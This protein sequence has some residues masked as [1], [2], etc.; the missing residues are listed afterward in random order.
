M[1]MRVAI[2]IKLD[3]L[4]YRRFAS[5][6]R[7]L[8]VHIN[9][10]LENLMRKF[11]EEHKDQAPLDLYLTQGDG[12]T[13]II[14]FNFTQ[15]NYNII[16]AKIAKLD[17]EGWLKKIEELEPEL[18]EI[19]DNDLQRDFW[20]KQLSDLILEASKTIEELKAAGEYDYIE[21]L[22]ELIEK[23]SEILRK[24]LKKKKT[25]RDLIHA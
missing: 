19:A 24:L 7:F 9:D 20:V 3:L 13:Q 22:Q 1:N 4:I 23:A 10:T 6:C 8:G 2:R 17:P 11:I 12:K 25:R 16:L 14:N 5:L 15:N 18:P 21:S